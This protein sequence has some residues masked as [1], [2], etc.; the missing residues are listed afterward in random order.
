MNKTV[1]TKAQADAL[2]S[3]INCANGNKASII[4]WKVRELF[5]G[6][7]EALNKVELDDLIRALYIGYEVYEIPENCGTDVMGDEVVK[8]DYILEHDGEIILE[9]NAIDYLVDF[10]GAARKVAGE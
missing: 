6:D 1:L 9:T 7:E 2:E 4:D 10:L 8:G 3:A 5:G